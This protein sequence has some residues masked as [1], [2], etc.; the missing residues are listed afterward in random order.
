MDR[1]WRGVGKVIGVFEELLG[2]IFSSFI[3]GD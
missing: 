3:K 2:R 1:F